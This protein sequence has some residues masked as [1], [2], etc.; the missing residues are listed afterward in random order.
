MPRDADAVAEPHWA[1]VSALAQALDRARANMPQM[2]VRGRIVEATGI[3]V[4]A[5]GVDVRMG[6]LCELVCK[7]GRTVLAETVGFSRQGALLMPYDGVDG[8][9]PS[10][11]VVACGRPHRMGMSD[12]LLGRVLD[13]FGRPIDGY[14]GPGHAREASCRGTPPDPLKRRLIDRALSTGVRAIDALLPV[15]EGQRMG[16]F[17]PAGVGK[18]TLLGMLARNTNADVNVIGLVGERG[19]EV[20]EFLEEALGGEALARSVCIIATSDRSAVE[21]ARA[22]HVAT[23]VAEYFRDQGKRVLLMVDSLT[24]FARAQRDIGLAC[25]EPPTRR[26]FTPSVFAELPLVLERAGQGERGSITAFYTV[27]M[28]DED[29]S[30][31]IAEEVRSILDGHIVLSRKLGARGHFPAIDVLGSVSRVMPAIADER[32][33]AHAAHLRQLMA[34]YTDVELLVQIGEYKAGADALA[35]EAVQKHGHIAQFLTQG[36]HEHARRDETLQRLA[37]LAS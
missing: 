24:R 1:D 3:L 15:G 28:E 14:P 12:E 35:D 2:D 29:M 17:A 13:G 9:S 26:A 33:V 18:S 25:G 34:K 6:E 10:T 4:K 37:D 30:D 5:A 16:I 27:L 8:L 31:P 19:R 21:R 22:V 36:M 32:Q 23:A 11:E 20:R 7:D